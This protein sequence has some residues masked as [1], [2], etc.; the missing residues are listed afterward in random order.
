[1]RYVL[2]MRNWIIG[3]VEDAELCVCFQAR[4]LRE[5]VVGYVKCFEV[6]EGR[7]PGNRGEAVRLYGEKS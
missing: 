5:G 1:M 7:E 3:N 2:Q 4:Y 6:R